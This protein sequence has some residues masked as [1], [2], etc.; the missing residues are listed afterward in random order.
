MCLSHRG[1]FYKRTPHNAPKNTKNTKKQ[2]TSVR[3]FRENTWDKG[4]TN[5]NRPTY[6]R[7]YLWTRELPSLTREI[8]YGTSRPD[9]H[10][11]CVSRVN[12]KV[13]GQVGSGQQLL[14]SRG[15]GRFGS[16]D[17][18]L[19]RVGSGRQ[20]LKSR[21]SGQEAFKISRVGSG[22]VITPHFFRWSGR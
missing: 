12:R 17:F 1:C 15:S 9:L 6:Q 16:G 4:P 21:G 19:S 8:C 14:K 5:P 22:P 13:A 20:F 7:L 2:N 3:H 11:T 10:E 18:Q